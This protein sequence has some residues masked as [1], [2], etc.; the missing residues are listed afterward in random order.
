MEDLQ[1]QVDTLKARLDSM[2]ASFSFP[3]PVSDALGQII[4]VTVTG[5]G[6]PGTPVVYGSFPVTV[7]AA[8]TSTLRV[9]INGSVY[10]LLVK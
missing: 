4:G 8:P 1:T 2:E 6:T 10:E 9:L 5:S 7:P 3:K